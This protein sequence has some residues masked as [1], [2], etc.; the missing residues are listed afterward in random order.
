MD[1]DFPQNNTQ[2]NE[3]LSK[4]VKK[5]NYN[6]HHIGIIMNLQSKIRHWRKIIN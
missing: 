5:T 4:N 6:S 3:K 2:I 1:L